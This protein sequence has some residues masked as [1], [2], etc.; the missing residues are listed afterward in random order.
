MLTGESGP[1]IGLALG[2]T[3]TADTHLLEPGTMIVSYTDGVTDARDSNG[4]PFGEDRLLEAVAH[5]RDLTASQTVDHITDH[6]ASF[7][8]GQL[9]DDI[10]LV[11]M[12]LTAH[13]A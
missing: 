12:K 4:K 5:A 3:Y 13:S 1:P 7:A 8:T 9:F 6:V 11:A 2:T 10:A